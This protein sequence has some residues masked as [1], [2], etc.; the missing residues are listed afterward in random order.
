VETR[1]GTEIVIATATGVAIVTQK[2]KG[3]GI[4][5]T[6]TKVEGATVADTTTPKGAAEPH[7]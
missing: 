4:A 7:G 3:T 2:D 6:T 1:T 5:G